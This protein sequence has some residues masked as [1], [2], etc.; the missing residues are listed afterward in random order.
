MAIKQYLTELPILVNP[1]AGNTLYLYLE[2]SKVSISA[3]LFKENENQKQRP[4]FF[5]SK[6]LFE[7]ETRYTRLKQ[8]APALCVAVKKLHPYFQAYPIIVLTNLP[9][10]STIHKLDLSGRM[11]RWAIKLSEF[12]IQYKPRLALKG[13]LLADF[14]TEIPQR[15]VDPDNTGWWTLN[16]DGA[17][18]K[19][20]AGVGLQL[21]APIGERIEQAIGLEFPAST[22]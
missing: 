1:E 9:L 4:I 19:M 15:D 17:S 16:V 3:T 21:K 18:R 2:V 13:Q 8:A 6:S 22:N 7:P 10:R 5:V 14:L 20:R 11:V 12:S